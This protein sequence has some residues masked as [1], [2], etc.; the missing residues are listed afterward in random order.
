[1]HGVRRPPAWNQPGSRGQRSVGASAA[2]SFPALAPG[3]SATGAPWLLPWEG[4]Y[5]LGPPEG[6]SSARPIM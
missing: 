6:A 5:H 1:M 4:C 3:A 2:S